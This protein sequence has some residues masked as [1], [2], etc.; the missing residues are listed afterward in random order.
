MAALP[1]AGVGEMTSPLTYR[2]GSGNDGVIMRDLGRRALANDLLG[3]FWI[4][5]DHLV[6]ISSAHRTLAFSLS[7]ASRR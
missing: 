1:E 6:L 5:L 7:R 2:V 3:P 4:C